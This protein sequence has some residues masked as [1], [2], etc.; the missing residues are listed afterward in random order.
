MNDSNPS[1][2]N[3]TGGRWM[4]DEKV[5]QDVICRRKESVSMIFADQK[6]EFC[7]LWHLI[8]SRDYEIMSL[9]W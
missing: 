5:K 8:L 1:F 2:E 4:A 7:T 6:V 3:P 9:S